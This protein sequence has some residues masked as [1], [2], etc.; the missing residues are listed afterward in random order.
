MKILNYTVL[1]NQWVKKEI[2]QEI[3]NTLR[4]MKVKKSTWQNLESAAETMLGGDCIVG[5]TYI[6]QRFQTS[7]MIFHIETVIN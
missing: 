3:V 7:N 6:K 5:N 1:N 4:W 2:K